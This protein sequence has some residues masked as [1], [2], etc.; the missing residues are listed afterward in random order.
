[1]TGLN[2]VA[3]NRRDPFE[4]EQRLLLCLIQIVVQPQLLS[5][6]LL[7]GKQLCGVLDVQGFD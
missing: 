1:M 5:L 7:V 2:R 4:P 3:A 6:C